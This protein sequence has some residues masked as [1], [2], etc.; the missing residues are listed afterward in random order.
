MIYYNSVADLLSRVVK[1]D[2]YQ[3]SALL[4]VSCQLFTRWRFPVL[5]FSYLLS[6]SQTWTHTYTHLPKHTTYKFIVLFTSTSAVYQL[7]PHCKK[8]IKATVITNTQSYTNM[9]AHTILIAFTVQQASHTVNSSES[10][11]S[12]LQYV[13]AN[14]LGMSNVQVLHNLFFFKHSS[15]FESAEV[16]KLGASLLQQQI[17]Y[18]S[19]SKRSEFIQQ[20]CPQWSMRNPQIDT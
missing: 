16:L 12:R 2:M 15:P 14:S 19:F 8:F 17:K 11:E 1:I 5:C 13:A 10:S 3:C 20:L 18:F 7:E 6:V 4:N 9:H